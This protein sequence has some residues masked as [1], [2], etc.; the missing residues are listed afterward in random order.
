MSDETFAA[1]MAEARMLL[2]PP[3]PIERSWPT[4]LAALTFAVCALIFA[5]AAILAPPVHLTPIAA[6]RAPN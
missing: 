4:L 1:A 6:V 2:E 5:T 3:E